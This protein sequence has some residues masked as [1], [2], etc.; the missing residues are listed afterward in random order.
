MPVSFQTPSRPLPRHSGQSSARSAGPN[1]ATTAASMNAGHD[2]RVETA[3]F[4]RTSNT[5]SDRASLLEDALRHAHVDAVVRPV[6]ELSHRDIAGDAH[7]LIRLMRR[8][9]VVAVVRRVGERSHRD[10]A[11]EAHEL[12]RLML[13]DFPRDRQK[14]PDPLDRD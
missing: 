3:L 12:M 2:R 7:E 10:I 13:L 5:D 6:D 14:V 1:V 11:G 9:P 4:I 8:A